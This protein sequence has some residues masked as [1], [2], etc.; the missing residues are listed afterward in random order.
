MKYVHDDQG[1]YDPAVREAMGRFAEDVALF[2][3]AAAVRA[4]AHAVDRL[5]AAGAEGRSLSSGAADLLLR[6]SNGAPAGVGELA[7]AAGVS[8][9]NVTGLVDTLEKAGMVVRA[10]DPDDRRAVRV[11]ITEAGLRWVDD[12]RTPAQLA[13]SAMFHG[14]SAEDVARLRDLCLRLV[15]NQQAVAA[16]MGDTGLS[17]V[18]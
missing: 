8:S 9:R 17:T 11:S 3:A 13:M 16:R 2:E 15:V 1:L 7:R 4:A 14:F 5:R 18:D 10:A 6:L 12:F